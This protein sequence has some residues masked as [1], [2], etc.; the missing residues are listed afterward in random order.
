MPV[1]TGQKALQ[2]AFGNYNLVYAYNASSDTWTQR[3]NMVQATGHIGS[4]TIPYKNCGL[5][6]LGGAINTGG[7]TN[8]V[9][10]CSIGFNN[11]TNIGYMNNQVNTPVCS[12]L[13]DWLYCQSG[14]AFGPLSYRRKIG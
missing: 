5:F 8:A 4:S 12:L 6:V 13:G 11:W 1:T 10:Y 2:E 14:V 9:F 3:A 7:K